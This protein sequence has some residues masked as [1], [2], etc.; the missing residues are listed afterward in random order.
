MPASASEPYG[1]DE[2]LE[3]IV[4]LGKRIIHESASATGLDL[5]LRETPQSVTVVTAAQA[6]EFDL[7]DANQLLA[8]LP[9]INVEAVE[10]DRTYYNA[11]GFDIINFQVDGVGQALDWA[12][13]RAR[14][15]SL[16][17]TGSTRCAAPTA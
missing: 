6:K 9:G 2:E 7:T 12:C 10:T 1:T 3:S 16:R 5:S 13:R 8:S 14:S 17:M 11:R 4:V 15:M